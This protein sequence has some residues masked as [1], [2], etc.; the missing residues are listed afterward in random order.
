MKTY[1]HIF[2]TTDPTQ[3]YWSYLHEKHP[4]RL[5]TNTG[6]FLMVLHLKYAHE[7]G[8]LRKPGTY[9]MEVRGLRHRLT[10]MK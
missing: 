8:R 5:L 2:S 3:P 9:R 7:K 10:R 4:F 6:F 1:A